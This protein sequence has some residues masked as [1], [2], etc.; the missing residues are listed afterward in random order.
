MNNRTLDFSGYKIAMYIRISREDGDDLES[1]S[2]CNQRSLIKGYLLANEINEYT[3]YVD[4]GYS[5]C[6]FNRP[7]FIKLISDI[8]NKK[9]N[10]I[11]TKDLSRLGRDYIETGNY[12]EKIFPSKNKRKSIV[13]LKM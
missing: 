3:E 8:N 5:G 7:G 4:D 13:V 9:I 1:E 2:I 10:I 12:I 6:I 11:I